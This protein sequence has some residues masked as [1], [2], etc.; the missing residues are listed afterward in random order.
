MATALYAELRRGEL[1]ALRIEDVDLAAGIIR[2]EQSYDPKER[3]FV[4]PKS[5]AGKRKVPV[6]AVL[7]DL[8]C[9]A[10]ADVGTKRRAVLWPHGWYSLR[11]LVACSSRRNGLDE[12]EA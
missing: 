3:A 1:M 4:E 9:Q 7:R 2:V 10:Q 5:R 12:G 8:P 6:A 11:R